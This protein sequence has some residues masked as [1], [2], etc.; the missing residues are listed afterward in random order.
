MQVLLRI[1][2]VVTTHTTKTHGNW[3]PD[4]IIWTQR[5]WIDYVNDYAVENDSD[6]DAVVLDV[7]L[8]MKRRWPLKVAA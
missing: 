5:S 4:R 2:N 8:K 7:S 1:P 6:H 3:S